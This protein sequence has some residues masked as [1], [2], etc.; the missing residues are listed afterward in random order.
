MEDADTD[1]SD[2]L[3]S[4]RLFRRIRGR[5]VYFI[6][7]TKNSKGNIIMKKVL[8][9]VLTLVIVVCLG[10]C[11]AA[12][13]TGVWENATYTEDTELG[14]GAKTV[15]VEVA[16]EGKTVTFTV[17]TDKDTVGAALIEHELLAGDESEFGLY[18]KA[19]NGM[20]ADYDVNQCYWAFYVNGEY[21]MSG[22]DTTEIT[23]GAVYRIEYTKG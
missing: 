2:L 20:T 9:L 19:V 8:S 4:C 15:V 21:A 17:K 23:E 7:L 12:D 10:A 22:V 16:A 18:V 14:E 13:A 3:F 5:G 11:G 6:L 1:S